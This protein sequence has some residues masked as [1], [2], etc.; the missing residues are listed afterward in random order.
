MS[1]PVVSVLISSYNHGLY[2]EQLLE[3]ILQQ[4][5]GYEN[6]ELIV[7]DDCSTDNSCSIIQALADQHH[8]QFIANTSNKGICA[9]INRGI[10]LAKGQY[11]CITG[12]DDYWAVNKLELQVTHLE[13]NPK[14]AV[15]SGNVIRVD[16]KGKD[17]APEK[18]ITAPARIY[19]F[20][21]VFLRD[22][23]FSSTCAM[24]RKSV[25]DEV[26]GYDEQLKIED[27]YM[28]LKIAAAGHE[29]HFLKEILGYYRIH[30]GNTI[31]K[32]WLIYTEMAKI[33]ALY[34]KHNLYPAALKR[35]KVVYFP[36]IAQLNKKKALGLLPA[37]ISNTRFFYR[38]VYHLLRPFKAKL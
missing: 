37:A 27:Y 29:L 26:G 3:S 28:W 10:L 35:L 18:Q 1:K 19:S 25:L 20:K 4:S 21:E 6:I 11:I 12:S 17:L 15:C 38:G 13:Q 23:P 34:Q 9:N 22:F 8:F 36:Q 2:I 30:D 16:A 7:I 5:Y 32:S 31:H 14:A 33:L 24:I